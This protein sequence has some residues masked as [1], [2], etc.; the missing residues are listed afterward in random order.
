MTNFRRATDRRPYPTAPTVTK[1]SPAP[2]QRAERSTNPGGYRTP[3]TVWVC[4][5]ADPDASWSAA[6]LRKIVESFSTTESSVVILEP[7][8]SAVLPSSPGHSTALDRHTTLLDVI[9]TMGRTARIEKIPDPSTPGSIAATT[10]HGKAD[11]VIA[12]LPPEQAA[13]DVCDA[14][15]A[16][17]ARLLRVGGALA[18]LTHN[19]STR[20]HLIDPTGMIVTAGQ[21]A[22]LLYLQHIVTVL[23]SIHRGRII[24][25][26]G[27]R[28]HTQNGRLQHRATVRGLPHPHRRIHAD[29]LVF[30][31][32]HDHSATPST[33]VADTGIDQ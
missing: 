33:P 10:E 25:D 27:P 6:T 26:L 14:V 11:L 17:A 28:D 32:P 5:P 20:G 4:E 8:A 1:P 13:P 2:K 3:A 9:T 19:D 23:G 31:Q 12:S 24:A 16:T 22:D 7:A 29:L 15:A 18:V 30:A 21:A